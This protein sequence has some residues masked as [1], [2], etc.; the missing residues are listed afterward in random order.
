MKF[1]FKMGHKHALCCDLPMFQVAGTL[2]APGSCAETSF[3][4]QKRTSFFSQATPC[5][6]ASNPKHA[7]CTMVQQQ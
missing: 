5:D 4:R 2:L 1:V 6:A 7:Q 3:Q